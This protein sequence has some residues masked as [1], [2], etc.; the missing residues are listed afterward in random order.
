MKDKD[1][2]VDLT[3]IKEKE[4]Q[5]Q[6]LVETTGKPELAQ[7]VRLLSMYIAIYKKWFGELPLVSYEKILTSQVVDEETALIFE[8]GMHEA[9]SILDM[10]SQAQKQ[11]ED[12]RTSGVTIN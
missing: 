2:N 1:T 11:E 3:Q 12:C 6:T 7:C 10:V 4:L 5:L 8:N 9:I